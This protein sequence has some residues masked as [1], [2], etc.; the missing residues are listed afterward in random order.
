MKY[1]LITFAIILFVFSSC[2]NEEQEKQRYIISEIVGTWWTKT[3]TDS[4]THEYSN[5]GKLLLNE[6]QNN[7]IKYTG[8][9]DFDIINDLT[10]EYWGERMEGETTFIIRSN[11]T[12]QLDNFNGSFYLMFRIN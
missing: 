2:K 9:Y 8:N 3:S 7:Y 1:F 11:D 6:Y 4:I 10:M 12:L 5:Y